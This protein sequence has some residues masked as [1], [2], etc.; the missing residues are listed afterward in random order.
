MPLKTPLILASKSPRRQDL[1]RNAGIPFEVHVSD[2]PEDVRP[3]ESPVSF[4]QRIAREKAW[5]V[6]QR[7]P[8]RY[9]LGADTDVSLDGEVLGK[10]ADSADAARILHRLSN[11]RH[12]VTTAVCLFYPEGVRRARQFHGNQV[13]AA[14]GHTSS[15]ASAEGIEI[16][17]VHLTALSEEEIRDYVATGEPMDKAGAYAI[18][19]W[20]SRWVTRIEGDYFSVVGLPVALVYRLLKEAER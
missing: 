15:R 16:T 2:I 17:E 10:P 19:G 11:R 5:A 8:D 18:Q 9:V 20:A 13:P 6:A 4:A 3:G 12:Q 1:L 7:F 14:N